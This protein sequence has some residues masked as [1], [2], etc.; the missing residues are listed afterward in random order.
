[1]KVAIL[2]TG[3]MGTALAEVMLSVGHEIIVYNRTPSKTSS[4]VELGAVAVKN[5][6]DA[7]IAAD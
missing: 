2:G 6:A 5:P 4:L 1:M 7:I 3:L